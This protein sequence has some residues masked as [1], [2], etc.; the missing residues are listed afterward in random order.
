MR[1]TFVVGSRNK[2]MLIVSAFVVLLSVVIHLLHRV[3][4]FL[5]TYL[6]I[7]GVTPLSPG[8]QLLQN[9]FFIVP[10]LL[11]IVSFFLFKK[12]KHDQL[13]LL[14]TLTLTFASISIIAGGDGLVEYHF[15]IF[16]VLAF[17]IFFNSFK[18]I[19]ISTV[20]FAIQHFGGYFLFP[21]LLCGTE[22]YAFSL[23]MIH[24]VFLILMSGAASL[25]ITL[26]NRA[27]SLMQIEKEKQQEK[28][29]LLV[30]QLT[31]TA[32]QVLNTVLQLKEGSQESKLAS[33]K[34]L[35]RSKKWLQVLISS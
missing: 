27:T 35:L 12:E 32:N 1:R 13:P 28:E 9:L 22:N 34:L 15:S 7:Q 2:T 16:M 31:K 14:L 19:L 29:E 26:Q 18:L 4:G 5:E 3:F 10:I 24:A 17:I 23:L 20:I 21:Q 11:L 8:L 30:A 6:I 25:I 33:R